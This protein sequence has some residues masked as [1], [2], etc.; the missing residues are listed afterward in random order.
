VIRSEYYLSTYSYRDPGLLFRHAV[1]R[2][3][4]GH[5]NA[6]EKPGLNERQIRAVEYALTRGSIT[7]REHR[8]LT[9]VSRAN[10]Y[11][12]LRGWVEAGVLPSHFL[13]TI[14]S[15]CFRRTAFMAWE[16]PL[17]WDVTGVL[18]RGI[19]LERRARTFHERFISSD[20]RVTHAGCWLRGFDDRA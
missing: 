12:D 20:R 6:A 16:S 8:T 14:F 2:H 4:S 10:A 5:P 3:S 17:R 11:R 7:N 19:F 1:P 9:E 13:V 18:S 15:R